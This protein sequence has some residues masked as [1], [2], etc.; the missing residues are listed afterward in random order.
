[1]RLRRGA[2]GARLA[3]MTDEP[4][5]Q[6]AAPAA[7]AGWLAAARRWPAAAA[8]GAVHLIYPPV[9][10]ACSASTGAAH[11]L[12]GACWSS[13][14]LIERP[15]CER[16]GTPFALDLGGTLISPAAMADPPVF[17][18]ARAVSGYDDTARALVHRLKYGDRI[19]LALTMGRMMA[20]AGREITAEADLVVP[21]PLHRWRLWRRRFNQAA[22]LARVVG[23][24]AGKPVDH[25][26][27]ARIRRTRPQVGLSRNERAE[28]LQGALRVL[29]EARPRVEGKRILLVDDVLTTGSTANASA[30][31]LLR[32]GARAVDLL[33]FARV[34]PGA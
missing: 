5:D 28:N 11:G 15:Y 32:S 34:I 8:R 1:M 24:C 4:D 23:Q 9:C 14:S 3:R 10:A 7:L 6:A 33:T 2:F 31:A 29:D 22:A 16:L 21:V 26:I 18:R 20:L 30:R 19:E 13:L 17:A 12:C 27:L 25:A